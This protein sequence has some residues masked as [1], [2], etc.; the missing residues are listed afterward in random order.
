M[1]TQVSNYG[2][3]VLVTYLLPG[4]AALAAVL[5]AHGVD[6]QKAK[7]L[8]AWAADAQ[9]LSTFLIFAGIALMGAIVAS[10]QAILETF[11]LDRI[12]SWRLNLT[13]D[14]FTKE[15]IDY[16]QS[17]PGSKNPYISRVV[18]FFQFETR[19]GL[20][21]L[22]L[23]G[24]LFMLSWSH[25]IAAMVT[26]IVLYAVGMSHHKELADYRHRCYGRYE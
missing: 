14:E 10:G 13:A 9:F 4:I 21:L 20:S 1:K 16:I 7:E 12:T 23:G 2:F 25:A 17:L 26:G 5:I 15:W 19:M 8:L 6:F 3:E 18:L 11:V 24:F 22:V